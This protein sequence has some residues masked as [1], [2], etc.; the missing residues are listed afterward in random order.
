MSK[1]NL[2]KIFI[3]AKLRIFRHGSKH[4]PTTR[5]LVA[6]SGNL[7]PL[8]ATFSDQNIWQSLGILLSLH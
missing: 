7:M 5:I 3:D 8:M 4:F 6:P 1:L 2:L